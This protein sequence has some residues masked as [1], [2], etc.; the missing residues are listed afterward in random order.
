MV[1]EGG[2]ARYR[3]LVARRLALIAGLLAALLL[4]VAVDMSV[5]PARYSLAEVWAAVIDA[6][7]VGDQLRVVIWDIRMPIALMAV[8][9]GA[10]LSAAGAQMQTVLANPLA[11][12]FTLGISAAA[13]F[14]A[15]LALAAGV[16]LFPTSI[17]L[18]VPVNAFLMA[19]AAALFIHFAS[20]MRGVTTE[21]II[22]LGIAL[23]FTFNALLA[24]LEY[25]ASAA[26]VDGVVAVAKA[27][28]P[29]WAR[30][31]PLRRA[32]I[33]DRFKALLIENADPHQRLG[34]IQ[35]AQHGLVPGDQLGRGVE[36]RDGLV[37]EIE[38]GQQQ[39]VA[40]QLLRGAGARGGGG[41]MA[42]IRG[43]R[44]AARRRAGA[45]SVPATCPSSR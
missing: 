12:P 25:L 16:S 7:S 27:A 3:G 29:D 10:S 42:R 45:G 17:H 1:A 24:L 19:V 8:V 15:A 39:V 5:G 23:V 36:H 33:L 14:G 22:L 4:S 9:V 30:T 11:S 34:E 2:G 38:A 41:F 20:M 32:R 28:W 18:A 6:P 44:A 43:C 37:E 21:T 31:P 26:E 40:A 35:Q 13:A